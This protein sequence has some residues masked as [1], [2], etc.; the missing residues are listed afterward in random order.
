[1]KSKTEKSF[2]DT[3]INPIVGFIVDRRDHSSKEKT[4]FSI[5]DGVSVTLKKY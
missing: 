1:M 3:R 5:R 4:E 2:W